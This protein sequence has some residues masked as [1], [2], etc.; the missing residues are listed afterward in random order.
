LRTALW[1]SVERTARSSDLR[2]ALVGTSNLAQWPG[3]L[4]LR[5]MAATWRTASG[6]GVGVGF[7]VGAGVGVEGLGLG[8]GLELELELK[9]GG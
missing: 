6:W 3:I 1:G 2:A 7:G 8:L 9:G 5:T 4:F